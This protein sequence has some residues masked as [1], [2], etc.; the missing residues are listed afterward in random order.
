MDK[1]QHS[2][3]GLDSVASSDRWENGVSNVSTRNHTDKNIA[4]SDNTFTMKK[5]VTVTMTKYC[6]SDK[7]I[8]AI[9]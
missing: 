6:P 7:E 9:S 8:I 3:N 4:T 1:R 2:A 5:N